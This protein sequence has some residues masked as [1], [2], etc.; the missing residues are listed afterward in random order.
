MAS[1]LDPPR[2]LPWWWAGEER[3]AWPETEP[4]ERAEIVVI[5]AGLA[6]VS[7]AWSLAEAGR[8]VLLLDAG[9]PGDDVAACG[10]GGVTDQVGIG[11]AGLARRHGTARAVA[12]AREAVA[13]FDWFEDLLA[14]HRIACDYRPKGRLHLA[15]TAEDFA[16]LRADVDFA[17]RHDLPSSGLVGRDDPHGLIAG[18]GFAGG[19]LHG[20]GGHLDPHKLHAGLLSLAVASGVKVVGRCAVLNVARPATGFDVQTELGGIRADSVVF[21]ANGLNDRPIAGLPGMPAGI[22]AIACAT[23]RLGKERVADLIPDGRLLRDSRRLPRQFRP[24]DDGE[25][26]LALLP[27][28]QPWRSVWPVRPGRELAAM[29]PELKGSAFSHIWAAR[30]DLP[31]D[32]LPAIVR[33]DGLH[34]VVGAGGTGLVLALWLGRALA[35]GITGDEAGHS[36][37][38]VDAG[39][40][41]Q[42]RSGTGWLHSPA[43]AWAAGRDRMGR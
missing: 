33:Q 34:R 40:H 29:F 1:G 8:D 2:Q 23:D 20:R 7:A 21:V 17:A 42:V 3:R 14:Q 15:A 19:V 31:F 32:E 13:A 27:C 39:K 4:P 16:A 6:G 41:G 22:T 37:F 12:L 26:L 35:R 9:D 11:L 30:A 36:A 18:T 25:R 38:S 43:L 5:G 10:I 28:P 24:A